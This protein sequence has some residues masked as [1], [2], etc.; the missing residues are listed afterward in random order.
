MNNYFKLIP[1]K[2]KYQIKLDQDLIK[3]NNN[4]K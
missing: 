3:L 1:K 2:N 4:K